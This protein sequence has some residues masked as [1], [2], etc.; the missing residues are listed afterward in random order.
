MEKVQEVSS[1]MVGS[2][3]FLL[4]GT[5][6]IGGSLSFLGFMV[7]AP[8][9]LG[10]FGLCMSSISRLNQLQLIPELFRRAA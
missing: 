2:S 5:I 6:L 7:F 3:L 10:G 9:T 8:M 1:L 4:G